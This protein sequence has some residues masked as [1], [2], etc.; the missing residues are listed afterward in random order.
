MFSGLILILLAISVWF[1]NLF[2]GFGKWL[3]GI[4]SAFAMSI[5]T[6]STAPTVKKEPIPTAVKQGHPVTVVPS[7]ATV[8]I[9]VLIQ[10]GD[11]TIRATARGGYP[12]GLS[13][14]IKWAREDGYKVQSE[15]GY[16]HAPTLGLGDSLEYKDGRWI[17]HR[18]KKWPHHTTSVMQHNSNYFS[19]GDS[20]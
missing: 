14:S 8:P 3:A 4:L 9:L 11:G 19:W 13:E 20:Y 18:P 10:P 15:H 2:S 5:P 12:L 16:I 6:C 1:A 7:V 17:L